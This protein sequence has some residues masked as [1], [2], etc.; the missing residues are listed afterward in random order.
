MKTNE[1]RRD[2]GAMETPDPSGALAAVGAL[3]AERR[4]FE[5]WIA[6]LTARRASTP[7]H[8]FERVHLDYT[9]RLDAVIEQLTSHGDELRRAMEA[10]TARLTELSAE[11]LRADDERSE[12]E[13]RAHVGELSS[14]DWQ[15]TAT[16]S[17]ATIADLAARR[18]DAERELGRMRELLDSTAR[19]PVAEDPPKPIAP[20]PAV[21]Q[22]V[23]PPVP[24]T[25]KGVA[26]SSASAPAAGPG[27]A[28][29]VSAQV[30]AP[31]EP[32]LPRE[33]PPAVIAAEQRLLDIEER[34]VA[35]APAVVPPIEAPPTPAPVPRRLNGFDELAF[36]S[37][38]VDTPAGT[39]EPAPADLPD[40]KARRDTF[41]MRSKEE[42]I[43]NLG[44]RS[45][46]LDVASIERE[47]DAP[48]SSGGSGTSA[49][50]RDTSGDGVKSLKCGECG[51]L[52]YPTEWY[53]ERCGAELASL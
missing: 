26:A 14:A 35:G 13:L 15:N 33:L 9:N 28:P 46:P 12:A 49:I 36:L 2:S 18:G 34:P 23:A 27:A 30:S 29:R 37:S 20:V 8:V 38:V 47:G 48:A 16:A 39:F 17:D 50:G 19:P 1:T 45:T 32:A 51:A 6:A 11:Q 43:T 10:L 52:N 24:R 53:C 4:R 25:S 5:G 3:M 41:A 7:P 40:E 44:A 21:A 31:E 22:T 42:T